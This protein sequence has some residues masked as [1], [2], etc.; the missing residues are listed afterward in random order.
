MDEDKGGLIVQQY[1]PNPITVV[2]I[3]FRCALCHFCPNPSQSAH[4]LEY[5]QKTSDISHK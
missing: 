5:D 4:C 1:L 2:D 3:L